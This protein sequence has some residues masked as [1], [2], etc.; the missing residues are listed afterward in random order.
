MHPILEQLYKDHQQF[1]R[2]LYSLQK[3]VGFIEQGKSKEANLPLILEAIEYFQG[4]PEQWHHP[5]EEAIFA[6]L[7]RKIA[8][9]VS[10]I[11]IQAQHAELEAMALQVR[12]LFDAMRDKQELPV[13]QI[14]DIYRGFVVVMSDHIDHENHLIYPLIESNLTAED[15]KEVE[16]VA[17]EKAG[18]T[19]G[20]Q[21]NAKYQRLYNHILSCEKSPI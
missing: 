12:D 9:P 17:A 8:A 7:L 4:Y 13:E 10:I 16:K 1:Q 11:Q 19:V 3:E 18:P 5:V 14:I 20:E 15:W 6:I 2:L 21:L